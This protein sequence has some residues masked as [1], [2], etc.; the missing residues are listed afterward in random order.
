MKTTKIQF[1]QIKDDYYKV[2]LSGDV[3]KISG[4]RFV[5]LL[6][7]KRRKKDSDEILHR[8]TLLDFFDL[9]YVEPL[10]K[11]LVG[12]MVEN[13]LIDYYYKE[14]YLVFD[15][16]D[17]NG[18]AFD[19][20]VEN[21]YNGLPD[22]LIPSL[23]TMVECKTTL[24]YF[25]GYE[26]KWAKQLQFYAYFWNKSKHDSEKIEVE[27]LEI[28]KYFIKDI[29]WQIRYKDTIIPEYIEKFDIPL[30]TE[31]IEKDL[32]RANLR[33]QEVL[34]NPTFY[35]N[36]SKCGYLWSGINKKRYNR[37]IKIKYDKNDEIIKAKLK[38]VIKN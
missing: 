25:K 14:P 38:E 19:D 28:I 1:T 2:E 31:Q 15:N 32:V 7:F 26:E 23:K 30:D 22:G 4:K 33:L 16:N 13:A 17:Y 35:V 20:G 10:N 27:K 24:R 5:S 9:D 21:H 6:G 11:I 36:I 12:E 29:E 8:E 34:S 3:K 18:N 37:E